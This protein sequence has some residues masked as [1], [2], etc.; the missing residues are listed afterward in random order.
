MNPNKQYL[1]YTHFN[2]SKEQN[3][4]YTNYNNKYVQWFAMDCLQVATTSMEPPLMCQ[5]SNTTQNFF[6]KFLCNYFFFRNLNCF[7]FY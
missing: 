7:L 3:S 5:A 6:S 1:H 2:A 4:K